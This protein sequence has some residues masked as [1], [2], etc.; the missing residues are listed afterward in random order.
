MISFGETFSPRQ[1]FRQ[2]ANAGL[3]GRLVCVLARYL[4]GLLFVH[5]K[6][7]SSLA[8]G[9]TASHDP[10]CKLGSSPATTNMGKLAVWSW[11]LTFTCICPRTVSG[12]PE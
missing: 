12:E 4:P 8:S 3:H 10:A 7:A 9:G 5:G 11:Y 1:S 6:F 2:A